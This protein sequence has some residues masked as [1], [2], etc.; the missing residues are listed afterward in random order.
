VAFNGR[1]D[2]LALD[3]RTVSTCTG[4]QVSVEDWGG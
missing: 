3:G 2:S 1:W 4:G